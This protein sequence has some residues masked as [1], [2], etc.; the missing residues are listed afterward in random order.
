MERGSKKL[1]S[2]QT[3]PGISS[4][5]GPCR[6]PGDNF[7]N[8]WGAACP[9]AATAGPAAG[10]PASPARAGAAAG[11]V[12]PRHMLGS[13][14]ARSLE[15]TNARCRA[16]PGSCVPD[17][18]SFQTKFSEP[19]P[20]QGPCRVAH[21]QLPALHLHVALLDDVVEIGR[22]GFPTFFWVPGLAKARGGMPRWPQF[23][24]PLITC[25][26]HSFWVSAH[27]TQPGGSSPHTPQHCSSSSFAQ[28][29]LEI[30][31]TG[32]LDSDIFLFP[33]LSRSFFLPLPTLFPPSLLPPFFLPFPP[34]PWTTEPFRKT[35]V[36]AARRKMVQPSPLP[37][38]WG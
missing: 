11:R 31:M 10:M 34:H 13:P 17:P 18:A 16:Q 27:T 25:S 32:R 14:L 30:K 22:H 38:G 19:V 2:A 15:T 35:E 29:L 26:R 20:G 3:Q 8:S 23:P 5:P 4:A 28:R 33:W 6:C 36:E 7:N 1:V 37:P 9:S 12:G 21:P 24:A